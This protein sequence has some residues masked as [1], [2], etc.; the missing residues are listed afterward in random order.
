MHSFLIDGGVS[1]RGDIGI[2]GAK[3][4]ALPVCCAALLTDEPVILHRV[5]QL[6]D[7]ST[8]LYMLSSLGKRV[9]RN[10]DNVS[11]AS[12]GSLRSEANAYSVRQMRASFLVLGPLAAR[13]GRASVPLPGGCVIGAR[14]VDL[15]LDGLR[16]MGARVDEHPG[17]VEVSVDRLHGAHIVL[18]YPSVGATEQLLM[19]ACLAAGETR[20]ENAAVEPEI[21]DLVRLLREMGAEIEHTGRSYRVCGKRSLGGAQHALLPDRLEAGTLLIASAIT[22]GDVRVS[23]VIPEHLRTIIALLEGIGAVVDIGPDSVR[24]QGSAGLVGAEVRTSPFPG[25][26][27][28]LHPPVAALLSIAE[29]TST[30]EET[31]FERRFAYTDALCKM[32]ARMLHDGSMLS[33]RGVDVLQGT[34][35]E[36]PDLRG[37]AALV[38]AGLAARGRTTVREVK[39]IDRGYARLEQKLQS[40]GATIERRESNSNG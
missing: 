31:V 24:C 37:G 36:A 32:G 10:D 13:L 34:T 14:P 35:V 7:V 38:L 11:I 5:P 2:D 26:P 30:I 4:A 19:T 20:L 15:H 9:V 18:P 8:I 16:R 3:N 40:L 25:F 22:H 28:D 23:P 21:A 33:I 6:R 1:L 12:A 17:H 27:T 29:G 39:H